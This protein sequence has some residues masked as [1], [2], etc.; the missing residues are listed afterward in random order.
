M[1]FTFLHV[2]EKMV[3]VEMKI[4]RVNSQLSLEIVSFVNYPLE[5][6]KTSIT[7]LKLHNV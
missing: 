7:L 1:I 2:N 4:N 6:N 5:I 3:K